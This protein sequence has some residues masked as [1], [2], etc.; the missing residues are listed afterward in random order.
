VKSFGIP[1]SR[2]PLLAWRGCD[3]I[4]EP[5]FRHLPGGLIREAI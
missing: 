2:P 3:Q 4:Q 1:G 5:A